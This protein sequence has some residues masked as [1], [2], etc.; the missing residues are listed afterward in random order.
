MT[1]RAL[2]GRARACMHGRLHA[3]FGI[4][5]IFMLSQHM[6]LYKMYSVFRVGCTALTDTGRLEASGVLDT[7]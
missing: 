4:N 6:Y 3:K 7:L 1:R 2:M 5:F